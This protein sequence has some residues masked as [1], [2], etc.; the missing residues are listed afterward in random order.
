MILHV[1]IAET[2]E[3]LGRAPSPPLSPK[4]ILSYGSS[5]R[6]HWEVREEHCPQQHVQN[7]PRKASLGLW[8]TSLAALHFTTEVC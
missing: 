4:Q 8:L 6:S 3:V 1:Y 2:N 7:K 5:L